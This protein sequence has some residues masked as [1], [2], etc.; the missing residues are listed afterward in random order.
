MS[1]VILK[2]MYNIV[3]K[4]PPKWI[5]SIIENEIQLEESKEELDLILRNFLI[6]KINEAYS[7]HHRSI[8]SSIDGTNQP[9]TYRLNFCL[10]KNLIPFLN[11]NRN[12][13]IVITSDFVKELKNNRINNISSLQ[14]VSTI[15]S[16]FKYDQKK[17]GKNKNVKAA[18]GSRLQFSEFLAIE[19]ERC[20]NESTTCSTLTDDEFN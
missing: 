10:D 8:D 19:E 1:L 17:L 6:N 5:E 14:E 18:F 11:T 12:K 9:F 20:K 13:E 2:E 15:I 3:Q 7:K 4:Q 16:G